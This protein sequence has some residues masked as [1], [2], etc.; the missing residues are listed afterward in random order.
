MSYKRDVRPILS[1]NCFPCHGFDKDKRE[2]DLRLDTEEGAEEFAII[3]GNAKES[4]FYKHITSSDPDDMMPPADSVYK[5]SC[6]RDRAA[7]PEGRTTPPT[8]PGERNERIR[9]LEVVVSLHF[10]VYDSSRP[11][12]ENP[13]CRARHNG[14]LLCKLPSRLGRSGR[15]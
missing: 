12:N 7:R 9:F 2:P 5:L 14:I 11:L 6:F 15:H 13:A 8:D 1:E 4:E 3:A 10:G